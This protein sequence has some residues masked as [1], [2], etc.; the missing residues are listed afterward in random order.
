MSIIGEQFDAFVQK[1][2]LT[3]QS[4]HG[5]NTRNNTQLNVLSN[6]NAWLKMG[7]SVT[8]QPNDKGKN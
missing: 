4:L 2:I 3:R 7:S 6:Q 1:Q 5:L 8:I